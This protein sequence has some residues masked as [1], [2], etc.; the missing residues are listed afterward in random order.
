MVAANYLPASND[1][2]NPWIPLFKQVNTQYNAGAAFDN[3]TVYGMSVGVLFVE[4]LKAAGKDLT[5]DGLIAAVEQGGF[6]GPGLA[7]LRFSKTDHSGYAGEQLSKVTGTDQAYFGPA[8][9]TDD[10][11][12][13]IEAYTPTVTPP[14]PL[15]TQK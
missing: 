8:Y 6:Q 13:A 10:G 3:N 2:S 1:D 15:A 9:K 4:A 12:G 7:P 11:D 5:R 14:A